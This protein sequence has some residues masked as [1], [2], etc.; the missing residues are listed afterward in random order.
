MKYLELEKLY[1]KR[2]DIREEYKK[3]FNDYS[4]VKTN[5]YISPLIRGE[6]SKNRYELFLVPIPK[7]LTLQN[8]IIE[9]SKKILK[10][11]EQ[12]SNFAIQS[13]ILD[14]AGKEIIQTNE[15]EGVHSTKKEIYDEINFQKK[16]KDSHIISSYINLLKE[17]YLELDDFKD[18]KKLYEN[19]F[20]QEILEKEGNAIDGRY[21]RKY[22]VFIYNN[23]D[24]KIHAGINSEEQIELHISNLIEFMSNKEIIPLLKAAITH[25]FLEYI[26]PFY[27]GN[28]RFGRYI[29]SMYLS[30]KYDIFTGISL[31]YA[32]KMNQKKYLNS[33]LQVGK[34]KNYGEITFFVISMLEIIKDGQESIME[35]LEDRKTIYT[36]MRDKIKE[37][38]LSEVEEDILIKIS[39][40]YLFSKNIAI[41]HNDLCDI[42]EISSYK[43]K[44]NIEK[45]I[46]KKLIKKVRKTPT[47]YGL[48]EKLEELID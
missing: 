46:E 10:I 33:F 47:V 41:K 24:K 1:Y 25:Y 44:Q 26:H 7:L 18:F 14:L 48:G 23:E 35:L 36:F 43:L 45:L 16:S 39:E 29:Y 28:G 6:K 8:E 31:S 13:C 20:D 19:L 9:N 32:I 22:P 37:M 42:L 30:R 4:T 12:I 21:F 2:K 11:S 34:E 40:M 15:I 17:N 5:L 3:R 27:D 38:N